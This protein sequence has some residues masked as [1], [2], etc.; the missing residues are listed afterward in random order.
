MTPEP[1]SF[2]NLRRLAIV[3]AFLALLWPPWSERNLEPLVARAA[4]LAGDGGQIDLATEL[5][6]DWER[7]Y[8]IGSYASTGFVSWC[9]GFEWSPYSPALSTLL[10][11]DLNPNE[12]LTILVLVRGEQHV[13]AHRMTTSEI[14]FNVA[15]GEC[16]QFDRDEA[17]FRVRKISFGDSER[18]VL[19]SLSGEVRI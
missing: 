15:E 12:D 11:L 1:P 19:S 9:L 16:L 4:A 3:V 5:R 18:W 10:G 13:E 8:V 17:T 14:T 2:R 6:L 7:G